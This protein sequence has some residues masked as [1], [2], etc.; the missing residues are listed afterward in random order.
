[1]SASVSV[2][3]SGAWGERIRQ[4]ISPCAP[5]CGSGCSKNFQVSPDYFFQ[6]CVCNTEHTRFF[7]PLNEACVCCRELNCCEFKRSMQIC[8]GLRPQTYFYAVQRMIVLLCFCLVS[9]C[10]LFLL[11]F[12]IVFA[13]VYYD[14]KNSKSSKGCVK[15]LR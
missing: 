4:V 11:L 5:Y 10:L 15:L 14:N 7:N 9:N 13:L 8:L 1:M 3:A 2:C 6:L 12:V